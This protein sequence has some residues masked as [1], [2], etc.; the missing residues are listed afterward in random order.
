M[1]KEYFEKHVATFKKLDFSEF[2]QGIHLIKK[3][4]SMNGRIFTFGNGGSA[5]TAS[6]YVTDW[7]KTIPQINGIE[8]HAISLV[9]N[10][11]LLTAFANDVDYA[12]VFSSQ[13]K[14]LLH[15]KDLVIAI[16]G[17]GNSANVVNAINF[18]NSVGAE[19]LAIVGFDGGELK[20]IAKHSI[21]IPSSDMQLCE[22][23]QLMFGHI[24]IKE[25]TN[26]KF[27]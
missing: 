12:D 14:P 9:D 4:L 21:W 15:K 7:N 25:L 17:S 20:K 16:S 26:K 6:H 11:G 3:T 18:A 1:V 22:D 10:I 8:V 19:T 23:I 27:E 2:E 24:V 13:L 5:L